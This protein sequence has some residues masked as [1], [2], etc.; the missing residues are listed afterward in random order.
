MFALLVLF[1]NNKIKLLGDTEKLFKKD[2][3]SLFERIIII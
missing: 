1:F 2:L 3:T